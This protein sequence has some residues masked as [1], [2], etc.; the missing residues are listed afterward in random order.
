M[1]DNV[2]FNKINIT[3]TIVVFH[4]ITTSGEIFYKHLYQGTPL[5]GMNEKKN[6]KTG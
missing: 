5:K 4:M 2:V 1:A 3:I 6:K